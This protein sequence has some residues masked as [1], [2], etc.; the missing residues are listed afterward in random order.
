MISWNPSRSLIKA[1]TPLVAP[2]WIA[3]RNSSS[4]RLSVVV[5]PEDG[6]GWCGSVISTEMPL[7]GKVEM[8]GR[9]AL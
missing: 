9:P 5:G 8:L 1:G 4:F 6:S 2:Y 3:V 7:M